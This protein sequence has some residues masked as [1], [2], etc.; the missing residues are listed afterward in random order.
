MNSKKNKPLYE[1]GSTILMG[2]VV[3]AFG[4]AG[5]AAWVS[6]LS[7]RSGQ[8][9]GYEFQASNQIA[10]MNAEAIM[11]QSV[12]KNYINSQSAN[13]KLYGVPE[14]NNSLV[15]R[16]GAESTFLSTLTPERYSRIGQGNGAGFQTSLFTDVSIKLAGLNDLDLSKGWYNYSKNFYIRSRSAN[17]SGD[18]LVMHKPKSIYPTTNRLSGNVLINGN[19][20]IWEPTNIL[21]GEKVKTVSYMMPSIKEDDVPIT[22]KNPQGNPIMPLNFPVRPRTDGGHYSQTAY[23]GHLDVIDPY[24]RA[25]WSV[26][27]FIRKLSHVQVDGIYPFNN[28]R[29]VIVDGNGKVQIDL[30]SPYLTNVIVQE[31]VKQLEINGQSDFVFTRADQMPAVAI[32]INLSDY[33]SFDLEKITFNGKNMRRLVLC[34]KRSNQLSSYPVS[35]VFTGSGDKTVWRMILVAENTTLIASNYETPDGDFNL[36]GGISTDGSFEWSNDFNKRLTLSREYSANF[37]EFIAPRLAW[38]ESYR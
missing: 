17:L 34:I 13:L 15:I 16:A 38:L 9:R 10:G 31:N 1:S 30:G 11:K 36:I 21:I 37:L 3:M 23:D 32:I 12:Y 8:I 26:Q 2:L 22:M 35:Y 14:T 7:A 5:I 29:G 6:L 27:K 28:G 24:G 25:P 18:L 33:S 4:T 20:F 19:S